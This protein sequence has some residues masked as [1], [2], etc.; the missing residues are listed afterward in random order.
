MTIKL[1]TGVQWGGV[2]YAAGATLSTLNPAQEAGLVASNRAIYVQP[3]RVIN[4]GVAVQA[5]SNPL[6]GGSAFF[7]EAIVR[8]AVRRLNVNPVRVLDVV[9]SSAPTVTEGVANG[10][11]TVWTNQDVYNLNV[12]PDD[13]RIVPVSCLIRAASNNNYVPDYISETSAQATNGWGIAFMTDAEAIEVCARADIA[14]R[15]RCRVDGQ[16]TQLADYVHSAG[17]GFF[18]IKFDFGA[19][20]GAPRLIELFFSASCQIR[21]ITFGASAGTTIANNAY[22]AWAPAFEH[23]RVMVF[24]DSY[25]ASTGATGIRDGFAYVLGAEL[26][27]PNPVASG[28]GGQGYIAGGNNSG[29]PAL[30]RVDDLSRCGAM[31]LVVIAL[32]INDYAQPAASVQSAVTEFVNAALRHSQARIVVLGP[33]TGPS[34]ITPTPIFAAIAAGAAA[35]ASE[36]VH[37]VD[38]TGWY[39]TSGGNSTLY[40][41]GDGVH[42]NSAGHR[43]VG[44]RAGRAILAALQQGSF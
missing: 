34:K 30:S 42:K 2:E 22:K 15:Y 11:S 1:L 10:N 39:D 35:A 28:V 37:Y 41:S 12:K 14:Y 7:P 17:T 29:N 24:G 18:F 3:P 4:S 16:W 6:T 38:T 5:E 26:G 9:M 8:G 40:N 33:W 21:G 20:N 36:R 27:C 43:Y 23:P 31:D 44:R 32:G 25:A 13:A 19:G